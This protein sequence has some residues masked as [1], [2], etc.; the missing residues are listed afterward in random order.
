LLTC[1][2]FFRLDR[3]QFPSLKKRGKGRFSESLDAEVSSTNPHHSL[4]VQ[5]GSK[6]AC[7]D[8][9][10]ETCFGQARAPQFFAA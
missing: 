2:I 8:Q 1:F 10:A 4:F 7:G 5:R 6:A 9:I 3:N